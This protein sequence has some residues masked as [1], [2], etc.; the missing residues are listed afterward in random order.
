MTMRASDAL[1]FV[2]ARSARRPALG[3]LLACALSWMWASPAAAWGFAGHRLTTVKATHTLP[4][5]LR[6][7]FEGNAAWLAE[8]AL[9]PDLWRATQ[10][11][12]G[13]NHYLDCDAFGPYPFDAIPADE[14]EHLARHGQ[15]AA[16]KGRVPWRVAEA[17]RELV[18]AW[19]GGTPAEVLRA[20]ATLAHYVEDAHVPLHASDNYDG[21]L[22]GQQGLHARWEADLVQRFER[23]LAPQVQPAAAARVPDASAL[24]FMRLRESFSAVAPLLAADRDCRGARDFADT[25]QDDRYDDAYYTCF[26]AHEQARL[27][28]R[29]TASAESLGGLWLSAWQD[30]GQPAPEG[31]FRMPYVRGQVKAILVSLDGA[32]APVIDDAVAR[33]IMPTLQGLRA[34][35]AHARGV[36]PALPA[37]TAPGHA[38]L[39]TGAWSDRNGVV[40][41]TQPKIGGSLL[42]SQS[43]FEAS[44]LTAEPI[45]ITAVRQGLE[46]VVLTP[47]QSAPFAPYLEGKR[48]GANFG[49]GLTLING[50][51]H[52]LFAGGLLTE[53][54]LKASATDGER[55]PWP[56]AHGERRLVT[57]TL[58]EFTLRGALFDDPTDPTVGFD[59]LALR[60]GPEADAGLV[61]K[62][63]A[64]GADVDTMGRLVLTAPGGRAALFLRLFELS[65]DGTHVLLWH[66][67]A[68]LARSNRAA[69]EPALLDDAG[70]L[71]LNSAEAAYVSG[72][73]GPT[74]AAGG[75]GRAEERYLETVALT[76]TQFGRLA[77]VAAARA[78]WDLLV[79]YV[80]M[81]DDFLTAWLGLL[82]PALG[83]YD[84]R[85]AARVRPYLDRALALV[86]RYLA[87]LRELAQADTILA[88]AAD[89][90]MA[91]VDHVLRPNALL[92]QAGLLVLGA[93]GRPDLARTQ[94][95]YFH[96]NA[97]FLK[98]N[99]AARTDGRVAPMDEDALVARVRDT[100]LAQRDE[101]GRLVVLNVLDARRDNH[102]FGLRAAAGG[103]LFLSLVPGV[104]LEAG[105]GA[106]FERVPA[107]GAHA[108]DPTRRAHQSAFVLA[109]PGVAAGADL[110]GLRA[111]D[112]AP[113][114]CALLGLDPPAQA[115]GQVSAAALARPLPGGTAQPVPRPART[116]P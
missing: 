18:N 82:D 32:S 33:G 23:Q 89:H 46:A 76:L 96:G 3:L 91:G 51:Q 115:E 69:L 2:L 29:L 75:D 102:G 30:A 84:A 62:P 63:R 58:A 105:L 103:D 14:A 37:K 8:H 114:L 35:G 38:A 66:S 15:K 17:Y 67:G 60:A 87:G 93:D 40:A 65:A 109:G 48:F 53:K 44:A 88:V 24:V 39:F 56:P 101:H 7:L 78:R 111:I 16:Q 50:Y 73:L 70:G 54:D 47:P 22:T 108:L 94:A 92:R 98:L 79:A 83:D 61:L 41:N 100:L 45:W 90:G 1:P 55:Q 99:R 12:E 42:D 71:V 19:R 113:T 95:M 52:A 25:P 112:V 6:P 13:P 4:A 106:T 110:G 43:G 59:S 49:R 21:Q 80:P 27:V 74:L 36:V 34:A 5:E 57:V 20:A 28:A 97:G 11:G 85:L 107:H 86:D 68:A 116:H 10:P 104:T 26:Y 31:A 9:D 77:R 81:P 72:A 64:A